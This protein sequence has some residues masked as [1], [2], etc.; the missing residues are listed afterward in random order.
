MKPSFR[1]LAAVVLGAALMT[2]PAVVA[3]SGQTPPAKP[4]A[5]SGTQVLKPGEAAPAPRVDW[6]RMIR[7]G[8][9]HERLKAEVG[10][11]DAAVTYVPYPGAAPQTSLATA[12]NR[13]VLGGRFLRSDFHSEV[14]DEVFDG[15]GY[16][17]FDAVQKKY[18]ST[19]M[20]S[21]GTWILM[22]TGDWDEHKRSLVLQ[23][24]RTD[25]ES[26]APR[27]MRS[28]TRIV[29]SD[30][31]VFEMWDELPD[32]TMFRSLEIRYTRKK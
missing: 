24:T 15:I 30:E 22:T 13:L 11:W 16:V 4:E 6:Q 31:H 29:S 14:G 5:P 19:W 1:P 8:P 7:P 28:V 3:S 18:V 20:D 12:E 10:T 23:G 21:M 9:E 27:R 2:A 32:G 17:G 25:P 26:G